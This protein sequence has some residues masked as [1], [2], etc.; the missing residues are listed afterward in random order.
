MK[1]TFETWLRE[2]LSPKAKSR[3]ALPVLP[4]PRPRPITPN[5]PINQSCSFFVNLPYEIRRK[6]FLSTFG[7]IYIHLDLYYDHPMA[8]LPPDQLGHRHGSINGRYGRDACGDE[9]CGCWDGELV[10]NREK[11]KVWYWQSSV[12]HR[13]RWNPDGEFWRY[14]P[15]MSGS[16]NANLPPFR[17]QCRWGWALYCDEW[18]GDMPGKCM[19]GVMGWLLSCRQAYRESIELLYAT[20]TFLLASPVTILNLA[21]LLVPERVSAMTSLE[22]TWRVKCHETDDGPVLDTGDLDTLF[23]AVSSQF[24]SLCRLYISI[25]PPNGVLHVLRLMDHPNLL[26]RLDRFVQELPIL[27][28]CAFA[29]PQTVFEKMYYVEMKA[30]TPKHFYWIW[31]STHGKQVVEKVGKIETARAAYPRPP[32][33]LPEGTE[34]KSNA[35]Y[36]IMSGSSDKDHALPYRMAQC[37]GYVESTMPSG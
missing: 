9:N 20:N 34:S 31:R 11:R 30:G 29:L 25:Q 17:D 37:F 15:G 4:N 2:K 24:A 23:H 33:S 35:G 6:T 5:L 18:P 19:I 21:R 10:V 3:K 7:E 13:K 32:I 22:L 14:F 36:Y 27:T 1:S 16:A 26:K 12:C 8:P 28:E